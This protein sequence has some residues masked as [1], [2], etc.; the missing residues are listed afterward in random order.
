MCLQKFTMSAPPLRM[1]IHH[2][3]V[4][5]A[6]LCWCE[7]Q[8]TQPIPNPTQHTCLHVIIISKIH[9]FNNRSHG[10]AQLLVHLQKVN[11][12]Q[13]DYCW[14]CEGDPPCMELKCS[15][16]SLQQGATHPSVEWCYVA[17]LIITCRK[18][19]VTSTHIYMMK[20]T[21]YLPWSIVGTNN[22]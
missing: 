14:F 10:W 9:S 8:P 6:Q 17:T 22:F 2:W 7:L 1:A 15:Q 4:L 19:G 5:L 16:N 12:P 20:S 18:Y 13:V 11:N 3:V 21:N